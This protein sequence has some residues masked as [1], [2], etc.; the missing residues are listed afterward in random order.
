M[1]TAVRGGSGRL[2]E[3]VEIL[4]QATAFFATETR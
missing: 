3:D 1:K 4:K 2:R